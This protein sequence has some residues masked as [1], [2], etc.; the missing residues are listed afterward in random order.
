MDH[1]RETSSKNNKQKGEK[2]ITLMDASSRCETRGGN[3]INKNRKIYRP[4]ASHNEGSETN[5]ELHRKLR[6]F[7]STLS[8]ALLRSNFRA[9]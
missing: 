7:Y 5:R 9:K 2:G 6:K 4:D 3:T 8:K 1:G